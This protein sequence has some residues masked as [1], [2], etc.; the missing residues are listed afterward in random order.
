MI[1]FQGLWDT[2]ATNSSITPKVAAALSLVCTGVRRVG[3]AGGASDMK[4][5]VVNLGLPNRVGVAAVNVTEFEGR[6]FDVLIGMDVI[7]IGDFTVTNHNGD[8]CFSFR[9]PSQS[10][11]DYVKEADRILFKNVGRNQPCPC[12]SQKKFKQ[13]CEARL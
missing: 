1:E 6:D 10:R 5:Y 12:G 4:A 13:C 3:H 11:V 7:G 8:T 2:G 9:I